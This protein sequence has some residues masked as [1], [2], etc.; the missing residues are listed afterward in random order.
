MAETIPIPT[1]RLTEV[2]LE[3]D[4]AASP[5]GEMERRIAI[6]DLIEN[7]ALGIRPTEEAPAPPAGPYRL[8]L[9]IR[10]RSL[11]L[12]LTTAEGAPAAE[13]D[14]SIASFRKILKDYA[15]YC[16][17]YVSAVR[18]LPVAE[19]ERFDEARRAAHD[20]GAAL[21]RDKLSERLDL[22]ANAARRLFTLLAA[23]QYR[24]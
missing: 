2:I 15:A 5:E 20:E 4:A 8:T 9:G 17:G 22:D 18:S 11:A 10:A 21:L 16:E 24:G 7:V 6:Y 23:L 12:G 19:I 3:G 13:I 14:L 1:G